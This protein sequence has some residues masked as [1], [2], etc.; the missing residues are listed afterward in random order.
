MK[1]EHSQDWYKKQIVE[2]LQE[3]S[4]IG[5]GDQKRF[6]ILHEKSKRYLNKLK[7]LAQ[8]SNSNQPMN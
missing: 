2:C 5:P 7:K 6:K 3:M 8:A 1:K 4:K